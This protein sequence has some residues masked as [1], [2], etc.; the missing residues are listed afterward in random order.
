M[1]KQKILRAF[2][3]QFDEERNKLIQSAKAAHEAATHEESKAEDQHDTF[4]IEASY[5]A[6]GQSA[7][8]LDLEST[9]AEY[10]G[11]LERGSARQNIAHGALVELKSG[12]RL[13]YSLIT[14]RGGGTQVQVDGKLISTVTFQ[15]PLGEA[16]I[17]AVPGDEIVVDTKTGSRDYLVVSIQ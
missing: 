8:I 2:I 13:I 12:Q 16:L 6:A 11:Y 1:D 17:N 7:R 10:L 5:L 9:V 14:E 4:A 3:S 15:S